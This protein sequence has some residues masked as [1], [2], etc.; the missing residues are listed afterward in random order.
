MTRMDGTVID[1]LAAGSGKT[2]TL[3][4]LGTEPSLHIGEYGHPY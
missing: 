4:P 2:R 1:V 3:P